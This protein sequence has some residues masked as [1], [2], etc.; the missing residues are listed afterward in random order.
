MSNHECLE[1]FF[2][3]LKNSLD[4]LRTRIDNMS[5]RIR[6]EQELLR[7][8][9]AFPEQVSDSSE[10]NALPSSSVRQGGPQPHVQG[11]P[12]ERERSTQETEKVLVNGGRM[13]TTHGG[14]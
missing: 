14:S 12:K 3:S 10:T 2:D 13:E 4:Y 5:T 8:A 9:P 1:Q 6:V 7:N 11:T